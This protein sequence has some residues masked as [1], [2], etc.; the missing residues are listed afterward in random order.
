METS[1]DKLHR[2]F[3]FLPLG[4]RNLYFCY[5]S[6]DELLSAM[7]VFLLNSISY[8]HFTLALT[9]PRRHS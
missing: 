7:I 1:K 5:N 4:L 8:G 6:E 2:I 9:L 3:L